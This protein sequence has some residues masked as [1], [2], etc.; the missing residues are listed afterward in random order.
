MEEF[1]IQ[2]NKWLNRM[3]QI[4]NL[5][6]PSYLRDF[7]LSGLMR[8]TS[9]SESENYA[10]SSFLNSD[11]NLVNFMVSFESAME[12]QRHNQSLLDFQC[13]SRFSKPRTPLP[14]ER[15]AS[16]VYTRSIFLIIQREIYYSV[17]Y[18]IQ[19]S[20]NIMDDVEIYSL[21]DKKKSKNGDKQVNDDEDSDAYYRNTIP[22]LCPDIHYKVFLLFLCNNC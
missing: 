16:E 4:R 6:I 8:T 14:I 5:W 19:D 21:K 2:N 12:K 9:R 18:C 3:Y 15:H 20:V 1:D 13:S 17:Y 11:C 10:F 7:P 22:D